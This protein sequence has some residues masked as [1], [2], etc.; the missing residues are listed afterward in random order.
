M[1]Y[2]GSYGEKHK[3]IYLSETTRSRALIFGMKHHL[4]DIYQACSNYP[5]GTKNGHAPGV[6]C[7]SETIWPRVLIIGM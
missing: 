4:V 1:F 7:W 5:P 6:T 2:I 3:K